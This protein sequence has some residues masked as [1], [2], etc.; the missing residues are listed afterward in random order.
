MNNYIKLSQYAKSRSITYRTA[1]SH[2]KDGKIKGAF[3]DEYGNI[4]VPLNK[5]SN[6]CICY[7]RVSSN[8]MKDNLT[9]QLERIENYAITNGFKIIGSIKEIG[10]GMN[11]NRKKLNKILQNNNDWDV[12][13]IENKDRLTRFGFNYIELLLN[14][15]NKKIIII[16]DTINDKTDLIQD[17]VSIIYSFSARLYGLRK[18]K[19]KE[20]ILEFLKQ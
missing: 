3:Q 14:T 19:K 13:I 12:L 15:Y 6:R 16:N 4:L 1:W 10:S 2:Y 5:I 7:A 9:R 17:L 8:E 18:K 11:D 20:D